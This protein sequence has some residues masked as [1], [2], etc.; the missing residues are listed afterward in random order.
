M[1]IIK[2]TIVT[3][4]LLLMAASNLWAEP[5]D[6][7]P[8]PQTDEEVTK[9]RAADFRDAIIE[10]IDISDEENE[11]T[12]SVTRPKEPETTISDE[13]QKTW[14]DKFK[15][16]PE[17]I[18]SL[19][20]HIPGLAGRNWIF[21][22][23]AEGEYAD[24][25]SDQIDDGSRFN[26]RS[27][28]VG[29][30]KVFDNRKTIKME[31]DLT[32][33]DTNFADLYVRFNTKWGLFTLGNQKIAQTLVNQTSRL[34]NTF[35][36]ESLPAEAFGL[37]RRL[38]I[39][40]DVH[41][42]NFG[43]HL[44]TFGQDI[45]GDAGDFGYGARIYFNPAKTLFS[46]FH[47]GVSAVQETIDQD[48]RFSAHPET[49]VTDIKLVDTRDVK[50][51]DKQSIFGLELAVAKNSYSLSGEYFVTEWDRNAQSDPKFDG[52]YL[53]ANW[54]ITGETIQYRQGKFLR[55]RPKGKWGAWE[56]ATRYSRI[57]LNDLDIRGGEQR[58]ITL[59]LNWYSPGNY[60]RVMSNLIF[61]DADNV[62]GNKDPTIAQIR[63]QFN[64]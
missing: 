64:W 15:I 8:P 31:V 9:E 59:G 14:I 25:S 21:F 61:I 43:G 53:Q 6:K 34:A 48:A 11:L 33:G 42:G 18:Q 56:L 55:I 4:S 49:R 10:N 32:D 22:G 28:R 50:N 39:G 62:T 17:T 44:T 38:G 24:F 20:D 47:V 1:A 52:Y 63:A 57:D 5:E 45:N 3:L 60:F 40:W 54:I 41:K 2:K 37:G 35:L 27:L 51:V 19:P 30:I 46:F 36:E 29:L 7:L 23:R 16:A 58:N 12:E 26:F 13:E